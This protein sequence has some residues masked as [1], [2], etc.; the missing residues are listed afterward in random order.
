MS[1]IAELLVNLG[2][3][4]SGSDAKPSV[5]TVRLAELGVAIREGHAAGNVGGADVVVV[6]SAIRSSNPEIV[7]A[8]RRGIP[9]IPRAEM[10]A[11][12]MR[13]R[14]AIAVA[15][16]HG[17]TTT[18]SMIAFVLER[19]GLDPDAVIG[20]RLRAFGSN[21]RLGRGEYMVAEADESDRSF[22]LL[23]PSMAVITNIDR[24][25]MESY[26]NFE[27]LQQAF[28]D[29]A[30][31]V[32]FYGTVVACADDA[33][34]AAIFSR[35]TRRL[36]T[37]GVDDPAAQVRAT[38]VELGSFGGRCTVHRR[39]GDTTERLGALELSIPGRHN[40][41]NAL[42]AA[43]VAGE[44]GLPFDETANALRA[45]EGAERRF[46]RHGEADGVVV[47]DD[48][49]HHPTEIAAVLAAARS[50]LGRRLVVAFQPHRYTRTQLLLEEFGRALGEADEIVLTD[51]Y[52][53][54]E[55]PI[56]GVTVEA[57]ADA[58]R[59]RTGKSV[60]I[61]KKVDDLVPELLTILRRGDAALTLGAG[62]IGTIPARLLDALKKREA[63][64]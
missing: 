56:P 22:L 26:R 61:V 19:G 44:L 58:V 27:E 12:L 59:R 13:M 11:E 41:Q 16:A 20:G 40:L 35:V 47:V 48:Y 31:K 28:T 5:A 37:Y 9:V 30:N 62:S 57:L 64:A 23:W 36:V 38:D 42:A 4:V 53:A 52:A 33:H 50:S 17:K 6:S 45:F 14:F 54:S 34:L 10:L 43:T 3:E 60:R 63:G 25:H 21:A 1:G 18:T 49:G 46:E 29:F 15:G 32:P 2:F 51:I 8:H 7:E 24:E 39:R 55:D